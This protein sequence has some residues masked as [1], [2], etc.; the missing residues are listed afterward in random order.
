MNTSDLKQGDLVTYKGLDGIVANNFKHSLYTEN[1]ICMEWIDQKGH[2]WPA[3][4][5]MKRQFYPDYTPSHTNSFLN[6]LTTDRELKIK[7]IKKVERKVEEE[8]ET[9]LFP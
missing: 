9:Y 2:G 7:E 5:D 6:I 4:P 8:K 3:S 1:L